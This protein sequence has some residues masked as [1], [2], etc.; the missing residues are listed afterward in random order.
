MI[1]VLLLC[2]QLHLVTFSLFPWPLLHLPNLQPYPLSL[3]QFLTLISADQKLIFL[4]LQFHLCLLLQPLHHL[5]LSENPLEP[6]D[7]PHGSRILF[8]HHQLPRSPQSYHLPLH[9]QTPLPRVLLLLPAQCHLILS[10]T[11]LF[12]L[13]FPPIMSC[14]L[15]LCYKFQNLAPFLRHNNILSG[16]KPWMRRWQPWSKMVPGL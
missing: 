11:L 3:P 5:L 12:S 13:P 7:L 1:P 8:V 14:H 9:P 4:L 6:Q 2:F 10:F 16:F 15:L